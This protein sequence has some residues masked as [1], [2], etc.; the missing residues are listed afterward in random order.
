MPL[1]LY[2]ISYLVTLFGSLFI[3]IFVLLRGWNK[4]FNLVWAFLQLSVVVWSLGRYKI[5]VVTDHATA[6]FWC[7]IL[8]FGS[9]FIY[10][11]FLHAVLVL[12]GR[13]EK[14][15]YIFYAVA[16]VLLLFNLHD[17]VFNTNFLVKDVRPKLSFMYYD[18]P[19]TLWLFHLIST[20]LCPL[21][22]VAEMLRAYKRSGREMRNRIKFVLLAT[23]VGIVAGSTNVPLIYNIPLEPIGTPLVPLYL[24]LISYAI[25]KYKLM[26][27]NYFL[28][29]G[30]SYAFLSALYLVPSLI[31]L[32]FVS[33][34]G[35]NVNSFLAAAA[36]I[37]VLG[38]VLLPRFKHWTET[39]IT[40]TFMKDWLRYEEISR[41][42][43]DVITSTIDL[44]ELASRIVDLIADNLGVRS[45]SFYILDEQNGGYR[46][47]QR[48]DPPGGRPEYLALDAALP[49]HLQQVKDVVVREELERTEDPAGIEETLHAM[50]ALEAEASVPFR[51]KEKLIAIL[52][53]GPKR[54]GKFFNMEEVDLLWNIGGQGAVALEN[55][56]AFKTIE[57][58]NV[59]LENKVRERTLELE[60]ALRD[61]KET[62]VQLVHSEKMAS[63]GVLTA[64]MAHELYNPLTA[65]LS[66][67]SVLSRNLDKLR[68]GSTTFEEVGEKCFRALE[69]VQNGIKRM[70]G[71]IT[72]L[73]RFS[74]KDVEGIK[75]NDI[76]QGIEATVDLVKDRISH[77]IRIHKEFGC[78]EPVECDLGQ[79][80]QVFLNLLQNAIQALESK[81]GGDI[82]ISTRV[83][84]GTIDIVFKDNA[85]GIPEEILSHIF[86]PFFTTK[87]V[88]KGTGLGLSISQ[89]IVRDHGGEITVRSTPGEGSE[90]IISLPL[91]QAKAA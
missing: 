64:G 49:R 68:S 39:T 1:I 75:L 35:G 69:R 22:A 77:N 51:S 3:G 43:V 21:I 73:K 34:S 6:L 80:N 83:R 7:R 89:R 29:R 16:S 45:T 82:W 41:R 58:L 27:I 53:L 47:F 13:K 76:N 40:K 24:F 36:C 72:S 19:N 14:L 81:G 66:S 8:M 56:I 11:S 48:G 33:R 86:E 74:R 70:E 79:I 50:R 5:L 31:F 25:Y 26:E 88:G 32:W 20:T 59:N 57:D 63:I 10:P 62:Q 18:E 2:Q 23:F 55:A 15:V 30:L 37:M 12:F 84:N 42:F 87:E 90:F 91:R 65:C 67:T 61:L 71:I 38:I 17:L 60:N 54:N 44:N 78:S 4:K 9:L 85:S 52:N 46:L 28:Y